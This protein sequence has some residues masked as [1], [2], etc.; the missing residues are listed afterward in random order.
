[1]F[2]DFDDMDF[3]FPDA[4]IKG[5]NGLSLAFIGDAVYELFIRNYILSKGELSVKDLH[6]ACIKYVNADFQANMTDILCSVFSE[7]EMSVFRRGKN[8]QPGHIP[9]NKSKAQYNRATGFE[10]VIGYL[11]LKKDFS[12]LNYIFSLILKQ[13]EENE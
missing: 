9:K 12:R 8:S 3:M 4:D 5:L 11:Y 2:L 6:N 7:E 10:A 13:G 1:M